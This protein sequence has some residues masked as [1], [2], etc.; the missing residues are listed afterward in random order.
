ML[1][2]GNPYFFFGQ[3][4]RVKVEKQLPPSNI[5]WGKEAER[6]GYQ[7]RKN[8]QF[9][10]ATNLL[11]LAEKVLPDLTA[12][13]R[14][15]VVNKKSSREKTTSWTE[16]TGGKDETIVILKKS[17]Q[18]LKNSDEIEKNLVIKFCQNRLEEVNDYLK[19]VIKTGVKKLFAIKPDLP[20]PNDIAATGAV[21]KEGNIGAIG[22]LHEKIIATVEAGNKT[23]I[24]PADQN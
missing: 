2:T 12:K 16:L 8:C 3:S 11:G 19:E 17:D 6:K 13:E 23:L 14:M 21:D 15:G 4:L 1:I 18:K 22:G 10:Q 20:V 7:P 9:C 24:L 5:N